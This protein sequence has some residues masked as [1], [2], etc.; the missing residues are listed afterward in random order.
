MDHRAQLT[1]KKNIVLKIGT[2]SIA[3]PNGRINLRRMEK[4]VSVICQLRSMGK[5]VVLVSSG[6]I[7]VGVGKL[8]M[9][10]RPSS[11]QGKQA[12]ASVG[13]AVLMRM[14]QKFFSPYGQIVAQ[15][16]LT[17]DVLQDTERKANVQNSFAKLLEMG[18]V[19]I[20][21]ENDSIA[22]DEIEIGDNDTL[23]AMVAT[24]CKADLLVLMSDI[25]GLFT[26]D[27]RKDAGAKRLSIVCEISESIIQSATGAGTSFGTG[28]MATKIKAALICKA[29][30]IPSMVVNADNPEVIFNILSGQDVGTLFTA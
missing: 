14:Y 5:N 28:G 16:L 20:V 23:S 22:T 13:Q 10:A 11:L 1:H 17:S 29:E 12:A 15:V 25:D 27:P 30:G 19:P 8:G 26:A 21:N 3:F 2:S 18:A 4:L 9:K 24:V 7:G 6:S